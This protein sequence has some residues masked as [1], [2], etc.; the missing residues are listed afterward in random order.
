MRNVFLLAIMLTGSFA[1]A[2]NVKNGEDNSPKTEQLQEADTTKQK[3][4]EE[5]FLVNTDPCSSC[6]EDCCSVS[7]YNEKEEKWDQNLYCC[8]NVINRKGI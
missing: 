3:F 1:L 2:N 4:V 7:I 6:P 5:S 8:G